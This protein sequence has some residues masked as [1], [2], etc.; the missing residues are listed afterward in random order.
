M[1]YCCNPITFNGRRHTHPGHLLM[2]CLHVEVVGE[3]TGHARIEITLTVY[4]AYILKMHAD[5]A[6]RVDA[7]L[8]E[9]V[10]TPL[11]KCILLISFG[12]A[13]LAQR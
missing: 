10:K 9:G 11:Q 4:L 12:K 6:M 7:W 13:G 1:R 8:K 3:R 5:A 2:D